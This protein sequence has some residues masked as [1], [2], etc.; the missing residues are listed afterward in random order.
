MC[1]VQVDACEG[2]G[3]GGEGGNKKPGDGPGYIGSPII[4]D[5]AAIFEPLR[6]F[7][8]EAFIT[9]ICSPSSSSFALP[10]NF[11]A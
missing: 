5:Q 10:S 1:A 8:S 9:S 4:I 11:L 6:L 3:G 7:L 2:G